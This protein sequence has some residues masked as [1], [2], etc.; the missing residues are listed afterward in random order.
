MR[1]R[2]R[3]GFDPPTMRGLQS[4][5]SI[6]IRYVHLVGLILPFLLY[7]QGLTVLFP[8]SCCKSYVILGEKKEI[9]FPKRFPS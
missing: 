5:K 9:T 3:H 7:S 1:S 4:S 6:D 2:E 8:L